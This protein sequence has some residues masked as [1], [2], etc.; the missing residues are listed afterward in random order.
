MLLARVDGS[1]TATIRHPS[2]KGWL[3]AVCQPIDENGQDIST[4]VIAL[5]CFGAA[6][7]QRVVVSSDGDTLRKWVGDERSP[8][9]NM[10]THIVDEVEA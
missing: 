8:L 5:D 9:R 3:L 10:I 2:A 6:L 4:P 7:H 1:A